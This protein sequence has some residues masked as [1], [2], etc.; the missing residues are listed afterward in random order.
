MALQVGDRITDE[1]GD[2]VRVQRVGEPTVTE[3]RTWGAHERI[4]VK[5][6]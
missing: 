1:T 5:R 4:S 3:L 6:A 2:W